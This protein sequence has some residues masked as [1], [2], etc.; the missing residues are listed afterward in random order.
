[1]RS[2]LPVLGLLAALSAGA[3]VPWSHSLYLPGDGY[4]HQRV[5]VDITNNREVAAEGA[6]VAVTIG[7]GAGEADLVGAEAQAVRVCDAKGVEMLFGIA[8]PLGV[9]LRQ[10]PIPAG[11]KLVLPAECAAKST[12]SYFVYFDNPSAWRVP[13]F[14]PTVAGLRNGNLEEGT[15]DGPIGWNHD[16]S[17]ETHRTSWVTEAPHSGTHCLKTVVAEGAEP[18]WIA[19]RQSGIPIA[20]GG[21]YVMKAWVKAQNAKGSVGWYIHVGNSANAMI[22][23]PMLLAGD[24]TYD[25]REVRAEFTAPAEATIAD[26]GTV[27]RG[28]GTAWFDDMSLELIDGQAPLTAKAGKVER[29]DLREV[30]ARAPWYDDDPKDDLFWDYR[31]PVRVISQAD[32]TA[33]RSRVELAPVLVSADL[34][35]ILVRMRGKANLDSLRVVQG[36]TVVPH[37]RFRDMVLFTAKVEPDTVSTYYV[38]L[39]ADARFQKQ[40]VASAAPAT[41]GTRVTATPDDNAD[42][43]SHVPTVADAGFDAAA[44]ADYARLLSSPQNLVKNPSFETGAKVPD[45]WPGSAEGSLPK[46]ASLGLEESGLFGKR[47]ARMS[48]P[49]DATK[50]WTGWRQDVPVLPGRT[51]LC[52]AWLKCQDLEGGLQ[53]HVHLCKADGSLSD[54]SP[55]TSAGPAINGT[56]DWTPISGLFTIPEDC[57]IFQVHLTMLATGTAWHDGALVAEVQPGTPGTVETRVPAQT[58]GAVTVWLVNSVVKVFQDDG[59]PREIPAARVTVA[60]NEKEPLQFAVRSAQA[61]DR[62][63][64]VVDSPA[65]ARGERL[66]Q[67]EVSVVGYVPIDHKTSYYSS[68][69]P[70]WQR[71]F[72]PAGSGGCD[73][74]AGIWPDPLLPKADFDL[75]ANTTQPVWITVSVP[76]TA[77]AGDYQGRMRL[78]SAGN[79]LAT[80]PFTVHVWDFALPDVNHTGAIYDVRLGGQWVAKGK[81][82]D[83]VRREFFKFMADNRLCPD[84]VQPEPVFKYENGKASADFTAYDQACAYYF[85]ELKFPFSYTP[86]LFYLFGW[87]Y[88]PKVIFGQNPFEGAYPYEDT[89]RSK[90]RPEYK[91]AYQECLRLYVN[92]MKEKGWYDK[93]VLY[94]S[95]EPYDSQERIRAQMKALCDMIHEVDPNIPIYSSTWHHQ[96]EWDGYITL[97]GIGH[98]GIVPVDR[99]EQIRKGGA[100]MWF[101]TDGQMCTDTPYCAV[102]RLLPH[103]CMKYG[104]SAYEFWGITWLTYNPYEFGWHSYISQSG[105]PGETGWVRYP[106]GDGFLAYPGKP[107]GYDGFVSS[108]RLAQA[109]E[110]VEDYEYQYLLRDLVARAQAAGKDTTQ[111]QQALGLAASLVEIPNAGGRYSSRILPDPDKVFEV[112]EAVAKAIE[113]LSR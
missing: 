97:W 49:A 85:D 109:R 34:S 96:P 26:L 21:K 19:T 98:Y 69:S 10:G 52:S 24:G 80:V 50:A 5:Q 61:R 90:L 58:G 11:S 42:V 104:V 12:A 1:M 102:E 28:T 38:Y 46:G 71:K 35:S 70:T 79:T 111:A 54:Y 25:W 60:R 17:D 76:K 86:G 106:N 100:K 63:R 55:Y 9:D 101:T 57:R 74:W 95:D 65:N 56:T 89:D 43:A 41:G 82:I 31:I 103:Y 67:L 73:G 33:T 94:I 84:R 27:L 39:S 6:P 4:W 29:M 3:A 20:G 107:I 108:V 62:V 32:P 30:G 53:I 47:C 15:S 40:V 7:K 93:V 36:G 68:K 83:T 59:A 99:M 66:D 110:G 23:S 51:Y 113:G 37:F 45:G 87:G 75:A 14:L 72:P 8:D 22:V 92:H 13:D 78:V 105:Q 81:T 18:T 88:P 2:M 91:R 48:I 16:A 77:A 112:K 44:L 64:V